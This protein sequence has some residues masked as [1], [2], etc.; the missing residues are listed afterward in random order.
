MKQVHIVIGITGEYSD[1]E[2]W[3]VAAF[4]TR[5][6][7]DAFCEQLNAWCLE[8][9][10]HEDDPRIS[11]DD[12]QKLKCPFDPEFSCRSTGI[13]YRVESIPFGVPATA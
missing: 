10:C 7:A 3:R 8:N 4:G 12:R 11:W 9:K 1:R 13:R 6:E 5:V 2:E